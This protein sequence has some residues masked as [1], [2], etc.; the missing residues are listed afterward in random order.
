VYCKGKAGY[1]IWT[2]SGV[3]TSFS[4][5]SL[6]FIP[7]YRWYIELEGMGKD[8]SIERYEIMLPTMSAH[9]IIIGTPY[10]DL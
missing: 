10:M 9:N 2:N 3:K 4:M 7:T 1:T 8:N 6:M 5:K